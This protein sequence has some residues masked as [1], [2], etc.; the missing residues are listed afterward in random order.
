MGLVWCPVD[1]PV[2]RSET[3][4]CLLTAF[5]AHPTSFIVPERGGTHGHPVLFPRSL[6]TALQAKGL[7]E[8]ARTVVR[9]S[10]IDMVTVAVDDEGVLMDINTPNDVRRAF[11]RSNV[12]AERSP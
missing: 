10:G 7:A 9:S 11:P 8:G 1:Y 12:V 4:A 5:E 3:V 2:V 6:F